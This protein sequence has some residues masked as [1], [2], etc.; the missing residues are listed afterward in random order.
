MKQVAE[1]LNLCQD[2]DTDIRKDEI[3]VKYDLNGSDDTFIEARIYL[4][5]IG[6][7][8]W[9]STDG[10][11]WQFLEPFVELCMKR[12]ISYKIGIDSDKMLHINIFV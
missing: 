8:Y 2:K 3:T 9:D 4:P 1:V 11:S 5:T 7:K 10:Y 6:Q 12:K